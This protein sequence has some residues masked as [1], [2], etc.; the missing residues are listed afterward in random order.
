MN[1]CLRFIREGR[2]CALRQIGS[3]PSHPFQIESNP[4]FLHKPETE[5]VLCS[6]VLSGDK[7]YIKNITRNRPVLR[8]HKLDMSCS[9]IKAR[10]LPP[11]DLKKLD[12]GV[13]Y[14]RIVHES[15]QFIEDEVR[16]SYH[17][18][19]IFCFSVD[20]KSSRKFYARIEALSKCLP[21]VL[22][23][24]TRYNISRHG[25]NM[26]Q[27]HYDCLKLLSD[28]KGWHYVLLLQ[29]YDMMIKTVYETVSILKELGGAND[30]CARPCESD[31]WNYSAN[32]DARSLKLF[33]NESQATA[34]QLA[35]KVT[36][37]RGIVQSALSRDAVEWAV[38]TVDLTTLINQLNLHVRGADETLWA[39]LQMSDDL[40]MP[41]RFTEK[42]ISEKTYVPCIS[43]LATLPGAKLV[44]FTKHLKAGLDGKVEG[45]ELPLFR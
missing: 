27:A 37:V 9:H 44:F 39:A 11:K 23:S 31:R 40:E 41:G 5:H 32:W 12:F 16:S 13:A 7:A 20:V 43:R 24:P 36:M 22:L 45:N 33:R 14:A 17:P 8:Y 15:Y 1:N 19:N 29:N 26:N 3:F 35:G 34:R 21:N 10:V 30:V 6:K 2:H 4:E 18:Q 42:C 25:H 28:F 38:K